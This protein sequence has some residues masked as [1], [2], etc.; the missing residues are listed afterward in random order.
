MGHTVGHHKED[1]SPECLSTLH[2]PS[3]YSRISRDEVGVREGIDLLDLLLFDVIVKCLEGR[4]KTL[5]ACVY[6]GFWMSR[7]FEKEI[8]EQWYRFGQSLLPRSYL[9]EQRA[10]MLS[11]V[12]RSPV[13]PHL[14]GVH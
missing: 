2:G 12:N 1:V 8:L 5:A 14:R 6:F 10:G 4:S 7:M 11:G 13:T 3:E 9:V